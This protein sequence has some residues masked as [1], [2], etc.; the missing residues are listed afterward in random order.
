MS[1]NTANSGGGG[2]GLFQTGGSST[3]TN[4]TFSANAAGSSDSSGSGLTISRGGSATLDDC[5]VSGNN[6]GGLVATSGG[7][8]TLNN[9]I[10][11][12][13]T[14]GDVSGSYSGSNDFVGGNP[15]LAPLGAYGGPTENMP[16]LPGSPVIDAGSNALIPND[17]TT[18][19]RGEPRIVHSFVDIGAVESQGYTLS[20]ASGSSPQTTPAGTA[21]AEPLAVIVTPNYANDP[22]YG[23]VVTFAAPTS[24]PS[25]TLSAITATIGNGNTASVNAAGQ[26]HRRPLLRVRGDW[27]RHDRGHLQPRQHRSAQLGRQHHQRRGQSLRR[28]DQPA[29]GDRL[30]RVALRQPD[31][32]LLLVG[33][34]HHR[35][36][37]HPERRASSISPRHQAHS[38]SRAPARTCCR[39]AATTPRECFYLDGGSVSLSG[40][41]IPGGNAGSGSGGGLEDVA[42]T[43][44]LINPR[45]PLLTPPGHGGGLAIDSTTTLDGLHHQRQL[46]HISAG[47]WRTAS[48]ARQR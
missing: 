17:I 12:G 35:P 48:P 11:A 8:L 9:T 3:L 13:N 43:A 19:Q 36:D 34:R 26:R 7:T 42:G 6:G 29:R 24:G 44:T 32:H 2:G 5:T 39:S 45:C 30:R 10:A 21:F 25:A 16:P 33:L 20:P 4:C 41:T 28:P 22:V 15:L 14:G 23:G 40:L 27:W 18:D 38:P 31:R 1:G 46:R 37:D 47:A